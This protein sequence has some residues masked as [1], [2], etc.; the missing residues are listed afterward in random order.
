MSPTFTLVREYGGR[1]SPIH[2]VDVYRL[3]RVQDVWDLG[4]EDMLE[5]GGVVLSS[6]AT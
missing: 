3:D 1:L 6:G 2:H 5:D 4:F